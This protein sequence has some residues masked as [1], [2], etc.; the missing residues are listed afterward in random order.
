MSSPTDSSPRQTVLCLKWGPKYGSDYVNRLYSMVS[1]NTSRPL[2]FVCITDDTAGIRPEVETLPMPEYPLPVQLR[3]HPFRRMFI[4]RPTLADLTGNVLHLDLDLLVTNSIDPFFDH[5]PEL[6]YCVIENWTQRGE[7][8]GNMS[9]FRFRVGALTR[10][11]D[12]FH[13]DPLAMRTLYRNSQTFVSRTLGDIQFFPTEWCLS[14]KHSLVP[15]WPLNFFVTPKLPPTARIVAFTGKPD[16]DEAR[17]G[18]WPTEHDFKKG[19]Q[20]PFTRFLKKCYKHVRPTPWIADHW[21]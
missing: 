7:G 12:R 14:F 5:R 18:E 21:R 19:K 6:D 13:P 9:V 8:I 11:W 2:R 10:I 15:A 20:S 17:R 3:F 16:I 4:F 1:R